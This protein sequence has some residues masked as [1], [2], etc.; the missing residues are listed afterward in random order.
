MISSSTSSQVFNKIIHDSSDN[1]VHSVG[2]L[3]CPKIETNVEDSVNGGLKNIDELFCLF[4]KGGNFGQSIIYLS[5]LE[6]N[7]KKIGFWIH[8]VLSYANR[9][10][11][12]LFY[13]VALFLL[14]T[15]PFIFLFN[16]RDWLSSILLKQTDLFLGTS[17]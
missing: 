15:Y 12:T 9:N 4:N 17:I 7:L 5:I 6:E 11:E 10:I 13:L 8:N 14:L 16:R 2:I 1:L 3:S